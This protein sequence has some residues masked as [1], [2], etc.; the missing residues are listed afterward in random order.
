MASRRCGHL[1]EGVI[2]EVSAIDREIVK[3]LLKRLELTKSLDGAS[4]RLLN[5][6]AYTGLRSALVEAGVSEPYA[7]LFAGLYT[8]ALSRSSGIRVAYL[9]PRGSFSEE[10][11]MKVFRGVGV[12]LM[13]QN[14]ISAVFRAVEE[15][16]ASYGVVPLENSLEGSIGETIDMLAD[17]NLLICG[18]TELRIRLNLIAKPGTRLEDIRVVVSNPYALGQARRFIET[19]LKGARVEAVSSTA[20]AVKIAVSSSGVAAIGSEYAAMLYG[21]EVLLH[22]IEDYKENYTRFI[23]IGREALEV[24]N[25]SMYRTAAI[26]TVK[27]EPGAL[28]RALQPFAERRVNLTKIESRPIKGRP[29]EYKFFVELEGRVSDSNVAQALEELGKRAEFLKVLGSYP[30]IS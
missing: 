8:A 22:G 24:S 25:T 20:E 7:S 13:P 23:V 17:S 2:E 29:W 4:L 21:G 19:V 1:D 18:D 14:S 27:H 3:L 12:V 5:V 9:G 26:F 30:R 6:E 28:Y 15:G 10:A 11:V 16:D